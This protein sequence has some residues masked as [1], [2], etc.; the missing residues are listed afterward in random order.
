MQEE[1]QWELD[2]DFLHEESGLCVRV[3]ILRIYRPLYSMEIGRVIPKGFVRHLQTDK[4]DSVDDVPAILQELVSAAM[5]YVSE[6]KEKRSQEIASLEQARA[7]REQEKRKRHEDNVQA[8][9][10]E[11]RQRAKGHLKGGAK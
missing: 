7:Q 11:N 1:K 3:N 4:L 8:R 9:R 2:R 6:S 10:E 5:L